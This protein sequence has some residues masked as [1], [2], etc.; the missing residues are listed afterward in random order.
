MKDHK[1]KSVLVRS[2]ADAQLPLPERDEFRLWLEQAAPDGQARAACQSMAFGFAREAI[3]GQKLT[4]QLVLNWLDRVVKLLN[5][6]TVADACFSPQHACAQRIAK[7]FDSAQL[8]VDVCVFTITDNLIADAIARCHRRGAKVRII[9]DDDKQ[10]DA[11]S[12]VESLARIGIPVRVDR[13][14][15]HM[16][17]KFALFDRA[18]LL[19][20]SY[21]WTLSAA[22]DNEENFILTSEPRLIQP[23]AK[24]FE[25]LWKNFVD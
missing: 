23:F 15:F 11:G 10:F 13:T 9:T 25:E 1:L 5:P 19:T 7:L 8:S 22:R 20:G 18:L 14:E 6:Q 24:L 21:N 16:H 12:D 2:L 3:E 4:P 17:H